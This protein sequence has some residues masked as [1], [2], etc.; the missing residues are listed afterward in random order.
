VLAS[1][2]LA[3]TGRPFPPGETDR[4][5][6]SP[7]GGAC[8]RFPAT[9]GLPEFVLEDLR[10]PEELRQLRRVVPATRHPL[11]G[12]LL[13]AASATVGVAPRT[14]TPRLRCPQHTARRVANRDC[15]AGSAVWDQR[16][17]LQRYS[18]G[19]ARSTASCHRRRFDQAA[20]QYAKRS[21]SV[22]RRGR[23]APGAGIQRGDAQGAG[24]CGSRGGR[25]LEIAK[26]QVF[27]GATS[28]LS[29]LNAQRQYFLRGSS[30]PRA[31][32]RFADTPRSSRPWGGCGI[33]N[34]KLPLPPKPQTDEKRI[35]FAILGLVIV[36][37]CWRRQGHAD[38][39]DDRTGEEGRPP[40][41]TVTTAL[42]APNPGNSCRR[43]A[44]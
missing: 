22:P 30:C 36:I 32:L 7:P 16:G 11:R 31:V 25:Y 26:K 1:G 40:P 24:G 42:A 8:R 19:Y 9:L 43:S 5:N 21:C 28:Q 4:T 2:F 41:E 29:L 27:F 3:Q 14:S 23:R 17:L 44:R 13:H 20:A 39:G 38:P 37:A 33:V 34:R 15:L 10:L 18:M 35:L 6:A 12:E